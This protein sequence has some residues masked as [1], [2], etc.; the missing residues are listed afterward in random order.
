MNSASMTR[1]MALI[2]ACSDG[3][4]LHRSRSSLGADE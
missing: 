3:L 2:A 1:S 4:Q